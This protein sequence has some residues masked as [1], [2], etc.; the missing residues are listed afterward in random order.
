MTGPFITLSAIALGLYLMAGACYGALLFLGARGAPVTAEPPRLAALGRPLLLIGI[1]VQFAATGAWCV[2]T[3]LSP[4]A[5]LYG[6]LSVLAWIMAIAYAVFDFRF[7]LP[8]VGAVALPLTCLVLFWGLLHSGRPADEAAMLKTQIVSLHVITI[9]AS[10]ALF[11]LAFGCACCYI[12]QN[13][14]LKAHRVAGALR[15]LPPLTT[16][17]NVAYHAVAY[18]LPLLTLGLA[19]GIV[20]MVHT[21]Q[22]GSAAHWLLDPHNVVSFATWLLYVLYIGARLGLGWRGVRLQYV[23][24]VGLFIS[25]ALYIVPTSTHHFL[26]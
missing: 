12:A 1:V 7:R 26:P 4:F 19:L 6:T 3:H 14:L 8:A 16:L 15:Y 18:A 23:L 25:L 2:T 17:D 13:R 21:T 20:Y 22:P 24:V 10:F 11:A 9:L 5:G